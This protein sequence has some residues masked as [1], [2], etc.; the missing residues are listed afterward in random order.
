MVG[1]RCLAPFAFAAAVLADAAAARAGA[2]LVARTETYDGNRLRIENPSGIARLPNG[3]FAVV[4]ADIERS[5]RFRHENLW[6]ID[7]ATG[8]SVRALDLTGFTTE[9]SGL[10]HC[11]Q[12][13]SLLVTDDDEIRLHELDLS[14]KQRA[15]IDLAELGA[16]DPEGVACAP[17]LGRVF[18]ADGKA[19]QVLELTPEGG[20]VGRLGLAELPFENAEGIAWD[21]ASG[22]L[23]LASDDPPA[24]FEVTRE[25]ALVAAHDLLAFG[26][27]R[28]RGL[29]LAPA[30][31]GRGMSL[32]VV[33]GGVRRHP[34]GRVLEVAVVGRPEGARI[35]TSLVGDVDGFGL[36]GDEPGFALGDLDHDGLLEPGERLPQPLGAD[37]RDRDD[38]P[39]TDAPVEVTEERPLA[40]E[41]AFELGAAEP[42]WARLTLVVGGARALS[43]RRNLVRADGRLIGEVVPTRDERLYPGM[44]GATVLELPPASLRDL[45]DGRLRVEI[46]REA[47]TG[48][49]ELWLDFSRLE[50][51]TP[52]VTPRAGEAL[53]KGGDS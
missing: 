20:L 35:R 13:D 39:G 4:D 14:G 7:L 29:A 6:E 47:G 52:G 49:D 1:R 50:V 17:E 23:W 27:V 25:G 41:H 40:L 43:G 22:H 44:I 46:A 10:A 30:S 37:S 32:Y 36:R 8:R 19:R 31:D 53:K 12:R 18:V 24:L 3:R 21:P 15:T 16:K 51:A 45:R 5:P 42:A 48:A 33:D 34:D 11:A 26:A 9:P 28:P 2:A 38:P